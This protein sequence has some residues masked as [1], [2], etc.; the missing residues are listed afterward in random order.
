MK[1]SGSGQC[2]EVSEYPQIGSIVPDVLT[3]NIHSTQNLQVSGSGRNGFPKPLQDEGS[4]WGLKDPPDTKHLRAS[5]GDL[6][7]WGS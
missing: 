1:P 7:S 6:G 3:F 5:F 2:V 4:G